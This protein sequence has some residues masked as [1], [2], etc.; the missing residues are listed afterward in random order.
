M[1][2]AV[3]PARSGSKRIHRKNIR[4][5]CG[6][7]VIAWSIEAA[8]SSQCFDQVI[9][10]TDDQEIAEV[11]RTYGATIPFMRPPDLA[12][13]DATT[14]EVIAHAVDW[15]L[16]HEIDLELV[17]CIYATAPFIR[18]ADIQH[19]LE[20]LLESGC[21]YSFPVTSFSFPIQ[22]AIRISHEG[23]LEMNAPEHR[24]TRSQ[25]LEEMYHDAGQF[26]WGRPQAWL[27]EL[28]AFSSNSITIRL[29]GYRVQDIDTLEDWERAEYM[30][31]AIELAG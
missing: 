22:R 29:P 1:R 5:F 26:Y 4:E 25:D 7:P 12:R 28:S 14:S 21:D 13:D 11:S 10:S 2:I 18:Y 27:K 30:F 23:R 8:R 20:L 19:G 17:C 9:V 16:Q 3:I 15:H 24:N 6:K 31:K